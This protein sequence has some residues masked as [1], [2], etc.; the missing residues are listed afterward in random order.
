VAQGA[1]HGLPEEQ[2]AR[3]KVVS[4]DMWPAFMEAATVT[5]PKA[6]LVHDLF[7]I[8]EHLNEGVDTVRK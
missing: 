2:R 8:M 5:T 3:I 6:D 7:H 1:L 4:L